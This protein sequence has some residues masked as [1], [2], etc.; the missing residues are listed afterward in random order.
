VVKEKG[1]FKMENGKRILFVGFFI[2]FTIF[3]FLANNQRGG[4]GDLLRQK[5]VGFVFTNLP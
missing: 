4:T 1:G 5:V 3:G 2:N